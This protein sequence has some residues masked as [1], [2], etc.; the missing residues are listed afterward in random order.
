MT[1]K[2]LLS[3]LGVI[4][5]SLVGFSFF[6]MT[7]PSDVLN[8]NNNVSEIGQCPSAELANSEYLRIKNQIQENGT[9]VTVQKKEINFYTTEGGQQEDFYL[10]SQHILSKQ[11]FYGETGR[12]EVE[13]IELHE[14]IKFVRKVSYLY[15][16]PLSADPSGN[17]KQE[18]K[19]EYFFDTAST[20]CRVLTE[21]QDLGI[22]E[23]DREFINL[24]G[25]S[26]AW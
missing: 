25:D 21:G 18:V 9:R 23:E 8:V 3:L 6:G 14:K 11:T 4:V 7:K 2:N 12:S 15:E 22:Q 19:K 17:V 13:Y 1:N 24:L 5:V 10:D 20:L 26:V 16:L